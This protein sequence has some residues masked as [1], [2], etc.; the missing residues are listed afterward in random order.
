MNILMLQLKGLLISQFGVKVEALE[1]KSVNMKEY[2]DKT[3]GAEVVASLMDSSSIVYLKE[4]RLHSRTLPRAMKGDLDLLFC[5]Q[6]V[7][8]AYSVMSWSITK[9]KKGA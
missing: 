4:S 7:G 3:R 1:R 6:P 9:I 5:S 2:F 8:S